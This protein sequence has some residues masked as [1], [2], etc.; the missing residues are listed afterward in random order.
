VNSK[1]ASRSIREQWGSESWCGKDTPERRNGSTPSDMACGAI[2]QAASG[3]LR[4]ELIRR[5]GA[6]SGPVPA[7][8][9][10]RIQ[11]QQAVKRPL[12]DA[13]DASQE[14][15]L[16]VEMRRGARPA[17]PARQAAGVGRSLE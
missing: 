17:D 7:L 12:L 8:N 16:D 10:D 13:L 11:S 3:P 4:N 5:F 2:P 9:G 15:G 6:M 1:S 14:P